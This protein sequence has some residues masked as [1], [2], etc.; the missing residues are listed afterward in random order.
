MFAAVVAATD[1][2]CPPGVATEGG[3]GSKGEG[4]T[5]ITHAHAH[6]GEMDG[7]IKMPFGTIRLRRWQWKRPLHVCLQ[8][9]QHLTGEGLLDKAT[10]GEIGNLLEGEVCQ[11]HHL[12]DHQVWPI[13]E[14]LDALLDLI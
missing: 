4:V 12:Q 3:Q 5:A 2:G 13:N 9:L 10:Q 1:D 8:T 7:P 14:I 11:F 6:G